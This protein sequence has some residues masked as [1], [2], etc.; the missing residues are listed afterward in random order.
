MIKLTPRQR[1]TSKIITQL[2]IRRKATKKKLQTKRA[3]GLIMSSASCVVEGLHNI[4][5]HIHA[6]VRITHVW[7]RSKNSAFRHLKCQNT[8]LPHFPVGFMPKFPHATRF[9]PL[10]TS[11]KRKFTAH[12]SKNIPNAL[13]EQQSFA[14]RT[15]RIIEFSV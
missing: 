14:E 4:Y 9:F 1:H 2:L 3:L 8:P 10:F 7:M 13:R 12:F 15:R 6:R 11:L 5:V